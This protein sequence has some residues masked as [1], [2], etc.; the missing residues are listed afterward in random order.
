MTKK[1]IESANSE[2]IENSRILPDHAIKDRKN[3]LTAKRLETVVAI[4]LGITTL[5][6]AWA[7]WIGSLHGGI[8]SIN[9][10]KSNNM[11]SQGTAEYNLEMQLYLSDYMAWNIINN[12]YYDLESAK[13]DGNQAEIN[14][15]NDKIENFKKQNVSDILAEGIKWM[16]DNNQDNPFKMPGM[17]EKYFESAQGKINLSQELLEEGERDNTKGDSYHLVTVIYSLTLFL[18]GIVGTFKDMPNRIAVLSIAVVCL[19]FAFIYM[20][21]I[22]LPTGFAQMNFFEFNQ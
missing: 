18:L 10:T 12:Y 9:F 16:E 15:I 20:C 1:E 8:Q 6:S 4:L 14:R 19:I 22:P 2:A 7:A 5:L 21:T 17:T 13:A 3:F 11:A